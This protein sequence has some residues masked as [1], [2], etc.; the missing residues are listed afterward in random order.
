MDLLRDDARKMG[1]EM[2]GAFTQMIISG[3]GFRP[4]FP[5]WL[6]CSRNSSSKPTS[7]AAWRK[8]WDITSERNVGRRTV[9]VIWKL[10]GWLAGG[11]ASGGPVNYGQSY[12]VGEAGPEIFTPGASGQ[13]TPN[14]ALRS[15]GGGRGG[16]IY[17]DA[18]NADGGAE[19]R[20]QRG[21]VAG[22]RQAAI[23]GYALSVE[24]AKRG[25]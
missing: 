25:A 17:V 11:K 18:R 13:I 19:Y 4:A 3:A 9:R 16:D 23:N 8:S 5:A 6:I 1:M 22:M 2:S 12:L 24:M 10:F 14:S 7:F 20:A 21:I 15:G